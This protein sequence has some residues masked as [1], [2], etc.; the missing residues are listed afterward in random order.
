MVVLLILLQEDHQPG[1]LGVFFLHQ[2]NDVVFD[3][4]D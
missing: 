3:V 1:L 4:G 2:R